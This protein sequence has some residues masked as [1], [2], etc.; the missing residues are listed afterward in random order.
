MLYSII[1]FQLIAIIG[2]DFLKLISPACKRT[3]VQFIL[4]AVD[5]FT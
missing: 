4:I 5:Y 3:G 2:T 1:K